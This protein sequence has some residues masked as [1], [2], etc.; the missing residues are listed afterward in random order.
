MINLHQIE[1]LG[2][3]SRDEILICDILELKRMNQLDKREF[4]CAYHWFE[5]Q[6]LW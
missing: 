5:L 6:N 4:P 1:A 2:L 3:E